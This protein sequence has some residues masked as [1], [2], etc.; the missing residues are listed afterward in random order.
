[1]YVEAPG[2]VKF[3]SIQPRKSSGGLP[4]ALSGISR[5]SGE[6]EPQDYKSLFCQDRKTS[7]A[8]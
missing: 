6:V 4:A 8:L 3:K 1:M 2:R 7:A 5:A